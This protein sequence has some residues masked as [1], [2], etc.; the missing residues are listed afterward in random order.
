MILIYHDRFLAFEQARLHMSGFPLTHV[1][2]Q[3]STTILR[4]ILIGPASARPLPPLPAPSALKTT[5][6]PFLSLTDEIVG[7]SALALGL[8]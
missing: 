5:T 6:H 3:Q 4:L 8:F 1:V 7:V 2:A